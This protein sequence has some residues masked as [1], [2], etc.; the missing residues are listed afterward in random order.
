M[1]VADRAPTCRQDLLKLVR[2]EKSIGSV[3]GD[4]IYSGTQRVRRT[5]YIS[6]VAASRIN[7]N[8]LRVDLARKGRNYGK[9]NNSD[10]RPNDPTSDS[11]FAASC[12]LQQKM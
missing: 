9:K 8:G 1:P 11:S 4:P 6:N 5:E 10:R 3:A 2:A 12:C 7:T